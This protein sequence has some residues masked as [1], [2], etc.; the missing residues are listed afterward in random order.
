MDQL[1]RFDA[2]FNVKVNRACFAVHII[3]KNF[4]PE[5]LWSDRSNCLSC[6]SLARSN[7]LDCS[8]RVRTCVYIILHCKGTYFW[9][10]WSDVV[11][12]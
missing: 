3:D 12:I 6:F 1:G 4:R 9:N 5:V 10:Q 8:K 7:A 11:A 2:D